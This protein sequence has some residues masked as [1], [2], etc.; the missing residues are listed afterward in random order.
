MSLQDE[1]I[2]R[3][4]LYLMS[5][6]FLLHLYI[7]T[8]V[9]CFE[10]KFSSVLKIS[11]VLI[12]GET[13]ALTKMMIILLAPVLLLSLCRLAT[14]TALQTVPRMIKTKGYFMCRKKMKTTLKTELI[15]R[16]QQLLCGRWPQIAGRDH[17]RIVTSTSAG[18]ILRPASPTLPCH[19]QAGRIPLVLDT[20]P[21]YL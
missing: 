19:Q 2:S 15:R 8:P 6:S 10:R 7:P 1:S 17:P 5:P 9:P 14:K 11:G 13:I 4:M 16:R 3:E 20:S 18:I 12:K 21:T